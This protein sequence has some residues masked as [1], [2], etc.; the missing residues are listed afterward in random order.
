M[1]AYTRKGDVREWVQI[2]DEDVR[3]KTTEGE[4]CNGKYNLASIDRSLCGSIESEVRFKVQ[5]KMGDLA[6]RLFLRES[7]NH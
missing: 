6:V 1:S 2:A 7:C 4:V 3:L 5:A